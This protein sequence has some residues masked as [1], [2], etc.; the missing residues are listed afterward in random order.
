MLIRSTITPS[1]HV[2][3]LFPVPRDFGVSSE[4]RIERGKTWSAPACATHVKKFEIY[5][6]DPDAGR[7]RVSTLRGRSPGLRTDGPGCSNQ[8]QD[9]ID[10]TLT[11]RRSCVRA[12][13]AH[14]Q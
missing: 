3:K 7:I 10:P 11:F 14:V 4:F 1:W 6:Y 2:L 8:D 12:S 13:A 5:R 9:E